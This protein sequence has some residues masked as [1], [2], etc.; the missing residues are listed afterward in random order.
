MKIAESSKLNDKEKVWLQEAL[1][2]LHV[3][4]HDAASA[5]QT[6]ETLRNGV[7]KSLPLKKSGGVSSP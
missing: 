3:A 6:Y 4:N 1:T 5:L 2:A 7:L